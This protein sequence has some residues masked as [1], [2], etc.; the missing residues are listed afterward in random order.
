MLTVGSHALY[1]ALRVELRG[2][3]PLASWLQ[4]RRSNQLSYSPLRV[5]TIVGGRRNGVA[6]AVAIASLSITALGETCRS[7]VR[8]LPVAYDD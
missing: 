3:E 4:T 8:P 6:Q 2:F 1:Q 5:G 7:G